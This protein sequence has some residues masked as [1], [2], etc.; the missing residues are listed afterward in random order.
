MNKIKVLSANH[1]KIIAAVTMLIDH[2]GMIFLPNVVILR[3][4]GRLSFPI[5][6]FMISEGARYTKNKLKYLLTI[7]GVGVGWQALQILLIGDFT[8]NIL[9]TFTM[10]IAIIYMLDLLK[11]IFFDKREIVIKK[12][13][14]ILIFV[15]VALAPYIL[16]KAF[17]WFD[18]SYGFYGCM[19][20]VFASVPCFNKTK[21]PSWLKKLDNIPVRLAC[22]AIPML[23]YSA[24]HGWTQF[25][26]FVSFI[27]LLFY[28]EKRG[29]ANLKYFFYVFYPAHLTVLYIIYLLIY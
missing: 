25:V 26:C 13:A 11:R 18:Y 24:A 2:I 12:I 28:S 1:L 27:L 20:A 15:I 21:A 29:T 17:S 16:S 8:L 14:F 4:I 19:S 10:S 3:L 22:M 23:I 6:A 5:F 9:L 7:A